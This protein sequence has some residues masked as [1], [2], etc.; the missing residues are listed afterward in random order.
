MPKHIRYG[1]VTAK[2]H[3]DAMEYYRQAKE[4]NK[5]FSFIMTDL[6]MRGDEG[7][8]ITT[9]SVERNIS[10][11]EA[12]ISGGCMSDGSLKNTG[13]TALSGQW[14]EPYPLQELKSSPG[15]IPAG[16][17]RSKN[18]RGNLWAKV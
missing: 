11:S 5:P 13:N 15:K 17:R 12:R 9:H 3:G 4:A 18:V 14:S 7:R 1:V 10:G 2:S 16:D 6:T 8:K